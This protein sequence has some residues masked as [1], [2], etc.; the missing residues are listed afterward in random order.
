MKKNYFYFT[1]MTHKNKMKI[2]MKKKIIYKNYIV[3]SSRVRLF[4]LV[5]PLINLIIVSSTRVVK[6]INYIVVRWGNNKKTPTLRV[7]LSNIFHWLRV[8]VRADKYYYKAFRFI[9]VLI[10]AYFFYTRPVLS[11]F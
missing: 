10:G 1:H 4:F 5:L 2:I 9:I 3:S 6:H 7:G 11:I 8:K